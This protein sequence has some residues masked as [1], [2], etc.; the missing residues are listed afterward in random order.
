MM[1]VNG[2]AVH[3]GRA[4]RAVAVAATVSGHNAAMFDTPAGLLTVA[5][6]S[7]ALFD[8]E[9]SNTLFKAQGI[10]AYAEHQRSRQD[11]VLEPG[12]AFPLL[13]NLLALNDGAHAEP[14]RVE[15][16][17]RSRTSPDTGRRLFNSVQHPL[18][19]TLRAQFPS[20]QA[21]S[22]QHS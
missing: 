6:S 13:R 1:P 17:L 12:I 3:R 4:W 11:D 9:E 10:D 7:R 16:P 19:S 18:P 14:P 22:P 2:A 15:V 5:I 20:C 8:L 21:P